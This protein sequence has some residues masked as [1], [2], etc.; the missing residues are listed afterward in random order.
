M[1]PAPFSCNGLIQLLNVSQEESRKTNTLTHGE[2]I[3]AK[4]SREGERKKNKQR[5]SKT[6]KGFNDFTVTLKR[7]RPQQE[8]QAPASRNS[9]CGDQQCTRSD[10]NDA[11]HHQDAFQRSKWETILI[12]VLRHYSMTH[13]LHG[14]KFRKCTLRLMISHIQRGGSAS[15]WEWSN[16]GRS[17][18][19][20]SFP[21]NVMR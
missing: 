5:F 9:N 11:F 6:T 16:H 18:R 4:W 15:P 12:H 14:Q 3:K 2:E 19:L 20:F 7:Y 1:L 13:F 21:L 17:K 10:T 8:P